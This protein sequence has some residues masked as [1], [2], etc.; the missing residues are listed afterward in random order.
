MKLVKYLIIFILLSISCYFENNP[1]T[2]DYID[3][4]TSTVTVMYG[5]F[6]GYAREKKNDGSYGSMIPNVII[7][8]EPHSLDTSY[9]VITD[10][11]GRY[12]IT[13]PVGGYKVKADHE[14]H[15][16]YNSCSGAYG[17]P[18]TG[19][20]YANIFMWVPGGPTYPKSGHTK[21]EVSDTLINHPSISL[22]TSDSVFYIGDSI[23]VLFEGNSTNGL[24]TVW[25]TGESFPENCLFSTAHFIELDSSKT[26][27]DTI[28][29]FIASDTGKYVFIAT[30][31]DLDN[32]SSFM[33]EGYAH[34]TFQVKEEGN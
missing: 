12:R 7:S 29:S 23:I 33:K 24:S 26:Y 8:F 25:W 21:M 6:S 18:D 28:V 20:H 16:S 30:I 32:V 1:T 5:E 19:T 27:N 15:E 9:K 3:V 2:E 13:L 14:D 17:L 34:C 22:S 11:I 4:D 10:S 31:S